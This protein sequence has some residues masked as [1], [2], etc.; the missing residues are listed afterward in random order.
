LAISAFLSP[1][2]DFAGGFERVF[3]VVAHLRAAGGENR[4]LAQHR[5]DLGERLP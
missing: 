3:V 1:G 4:N 2:D 5:G